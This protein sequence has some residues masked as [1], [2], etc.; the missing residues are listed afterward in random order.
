MPYVLT[1]APAVLQAFIKEIFKDLINKYF[2][3]YN[4]DILIYYASN[5]ITFTIFTPCSH[6]HNQ[7][8]LKLRS[9]FHK[10]IIKFL[11]YVF[12][13]RGVERGVVCMLANCKQ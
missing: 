5:D 9:V 7:L 11:G 2:I 13:Q 1:D 10:D 8:Y 12:S 3:I 4:D 6:Q